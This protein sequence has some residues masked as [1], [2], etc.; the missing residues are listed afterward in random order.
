[1]ESKLLPLPEAVRRHTRDGMLYASGAALPIGSD[2]I[3]FGRELVRQRRRDLHLVSHCCSQQLNLLA[4]TGAAQ[5]VECGFSALEG[6]GFAKGLRRA[7]ESGQML[8][9]DWSNLSMSLR[10][11]GGALG[12]PFVPATTNVGSD[13]QHRSAFAPDEYPARRKIPEVTD[14]FG[15]KPVGALPPFKPEL[16]AIH[17]TLADS[18]GNAIMLG[19]EWSRW[20]LSRAAQQVVLVA[21]HIVHTDCMQQFPNLVRIPGL[22][23]DAV[24]HW[25][26]AAWPQGSPGAYDL[27]E[28]HMREMNEA[29][30]SE[31]GTH[32]YV[33]RYV[34]GYRDI[35]DYLD[36][37]G[38][39]TRERLEH[40]PTRFLLDPFRRWLLG[41]DA[42]AEL[43]Q[44]A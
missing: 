35:D 19:T 17:V 31:A 25:P 15:G 9:E 3:V 32:A 36:L 22:I 44:A 16:A 5:R 21:D 40:G 13:L 42:I 39:E 37:I 29:L 4:A 41:R 28:K 14:P 8:L 26:F 1:V 24:V 34:L 6:F 18:Q 2:S 11:L 27:D 10:Y 12:W 20:E 7:V 33:E 38:A 43:T 23:V 30:A